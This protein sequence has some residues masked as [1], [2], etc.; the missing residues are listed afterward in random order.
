MRIQILG[1]IRA[2]RDG[3]ELDLG[4]A[5]RRA[6]LGLL[7]LFGGRAVP[8]ADMVDALWNERP[9]PSAANVIQTH[10]KHLRRLFE[11]GR[12]RYARSTNIPTV[13]DGYALRMPDCQV[14]VERFRALVSAARATSA[15][16][17][18]AGL[19]GEALGLW[20]GRPF[21]DY[22]ELT[23]HAKVVALLAERRN[24]LL[25]YADVMIGTGR[26]VDLLP[27]LVESAAGH[28]LDEAVQARLVGAYAAVGRRA[29]AFAVYEN[30]RRALRDEL[31]VGPGAELAD[32]HA[33]LLREP[34]TSRRPRRAGPA[35][36]QLPANAPGFAVG[37][38]ELAAL[39]GL[40]AERDPVATAVI[41]VCGTA[42]VGKTALAVHFCMDASVTL[43]PAEATA[44]RRAI[45][46]YLRELTNSRYG[47]EISIKMEDR[48]RRGE[49]LEEFKVD[50]AELKSDERALRGLLSRLD[51]T[52]NSERSSCWCGA[53][54][55]RV[56]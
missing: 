17:E 14:D 50:L 26:A 21:A 30:A 20:Q 49:P 31:A 38:T 18:A 42:G 41:A 45:S 39:D 4:P 51:D 3:Q 34:P 53:K 52:A 28:S 11:P 36:A 54:G 27:L 23:V 48:D 29:D 25:A 6:V 1:P 22:P 55:D 13:G 19:L 37:T 40:L 8:R 24:A 2:W 56:G 33:A 43:T 9:P 44:V 5:G 35:P 47:L 10:I 32:V 12:D 7:V 16:E 46:E 15:D